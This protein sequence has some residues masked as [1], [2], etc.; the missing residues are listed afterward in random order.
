MAPGFSRY[1]ITAPAT[2][3]EVIDLLEATSRDGSF[4]TSVDTKDPETDEINTIDL[5]VGMRRHVT[6]GYEYIVKLAD[7]SPATITA[8]THPD[9]EGTP[10]N[11]TLVRQTTP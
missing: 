7:G 1:P 5:M 3:R 2:S 9:L 4:V 6:M 10:A 11:L 8:F